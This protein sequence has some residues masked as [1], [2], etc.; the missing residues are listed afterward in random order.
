MRVTQTV[1]VD[2]DI[3]LSNFTD[4]E[5]EDEYEE[6]GLAKID[7]NEVAEQLYL[8]ISMGKPTDDLIR[9]FIYQSTGRII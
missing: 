1:D 7:S 6:R 5:I 3:D 9:E 4:E 2:L 8:T